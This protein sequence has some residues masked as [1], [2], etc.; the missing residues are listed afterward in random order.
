[1]CMDGEFISLAEL[2]SRPIINLNFCVARNLLLLVQ[3]QGV[4]VKSRA[5]I[6]MLLPQ[7][8]LVNFLSLMFD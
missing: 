6:I 8:H 2:I 7:G 1:M 5:L 4:Y 3:V